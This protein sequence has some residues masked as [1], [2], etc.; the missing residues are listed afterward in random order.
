MC[1]DPVSI[2]GQNGGMLGGT[3]NGDEVD[4]EKYSSSTAALDP[5]LETEAQ[6][7]DLDSSMD[8]S[9][10][11]DP[12]LEQRRQEETRRSWFHRSNSPSA[13]EEDSASDEDSG[14]DEKSR[15]LTQDP[16]GDNVAPVGYSKVQII[17]L[18]AGPERS[19][20]PVY[21]TP[22]KVTGH[23]KHSG[24]L[25]ET[26]QEASSMKE[27]RSAGNGGDKQVSPPLRKKPLPP[28]PPKKPHSLSSSGN[29]GSTGGGRTAKVLLK[30]QKD[31]ESGPENEGGVENGCEEQGEE[32]TIGG[33]ANFAVFKRL[34]EK[35]ERSISNPWPLKKPV[36]LPRNK[37]ETLD[38]MDSTGR[39]F[40]CSLPADFKPTP[41]PRRPT[42]VSPPSSSSNSP[43]L[44]RSSH[45]RPPISPKPT[46]SHLPKPSPPLPRA[47]PPSTSSQNTSDPPC[48]VS[49]TSPNS[50]DSGD[51]VTSPTANCKASSDQTEDFGNGV[52]QLNEQPVAP[53]RQKRKTKTTHTR[54]QPLSP[55]YSPT[56]GSPVKTAA[57]SSDTGS[58]DQP[59]TSSE[60]DISHP[61][62]KFLPSPSPVP[63][64]PSPNFEALPLG[65]QEELSHSSSVMAQCHSIPSIRSSFTASPLDLPSA[66]G[67]M[68]DREPLPPAF[69]YN[70]LTRHHPAR[71]LSPL[72]TSSECSV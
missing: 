30:N 10:L 28:T 63:R 46:F 62:H 27:S 33:Y 47:H 65:W 60:S 15:T 49:D 1:N 50:P 44:P 72:P 53:P 24:Q 7:L 71:S 5:I 69:P 43:K 16:S 31:K 64:S 21:S 58:S 22:V 40:G 14:E 6:R 51:P 26:S 37:S 18:K 13:P 66:Y 38:R 3:G 29:T 41:V 67:Y 11:M 9:L 34:D 32:E 68:G 23:S 55:I 17:A 12:S 42:L 70:T 8:P 36:P 35:R 4:F 48:S 52:K 54:P 61:R 20:S 56:Q 57:V 2:P 39:G 59:D 25:R 19:T 45:S